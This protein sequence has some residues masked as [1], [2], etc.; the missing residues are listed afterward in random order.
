VNDQQ[1]SKITRKLQDHR[2]AVNTDLPTY[3]SVI[4]YS[5]FLLLSEYEVGGQV[6]RLKDIYLELG[7]SQGG[8]RRII[9]KLTADGWIE[10]TRPEGDQRTRL[11]IATPKLKRTIAAFLAAMQG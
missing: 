1:K 11:V 4:G 7:R 5:L 3:D 9:R 8:V 10:V 2:S 6:A